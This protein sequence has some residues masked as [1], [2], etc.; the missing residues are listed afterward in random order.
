M[1]EISLKIDGMSCQHCVASVKKAL[2]SMEGISSSEVAVGTAKV[3]YDDLKT[4]REI[5]T[6]VIQ[7]AG[8]KVVV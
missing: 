6:N 5:I 2:D 8:Y 3:V 4:N 7:N 1:S